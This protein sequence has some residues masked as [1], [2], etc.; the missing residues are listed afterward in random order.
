M[1]ALN[2]THGHVNDKSETTQTQ[3]ALQKH[4]SNTSHRFKIEVWRNE[5]RH[6]QK[7]LPVKADGVPLFPATTQAMQKPLIPFPQ[8]CLA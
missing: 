7:R 2:L 8:A 6:P 5:S 4:C 3:H 1:T